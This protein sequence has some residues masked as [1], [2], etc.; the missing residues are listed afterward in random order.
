MM[1]EIESKILTLKWRVRNIKNIVDSQGPDL[2]LL[3]EEVERK[4]QE[5]SDNQEVYNLWE[6][7]YNKALDILKEYEAEND[8]I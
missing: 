7:L 5:V 8:E 6:S 3:I 1:L 4:E 2:D